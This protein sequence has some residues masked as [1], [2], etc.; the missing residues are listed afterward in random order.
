LLFLP[1]LFSFLLFFS[2]NS[3]VFGLTLDEAISLG[4]KN[5]LNLQKQQIDLTSGSFSERNVWSEIFPTINANASA[6]YR[7]NV[8]SDFQTN[9][10]GANYGIGFGINLGLNAGIPHIINNIKLAHQGNLLRYEDAVNQLSI[11]ITKRFFALVAEKNNLLLLEEILNLAQRQFSR[12]LISFQSGLVTELVMMQSRLALEN[13]RY[14]LSAAST[15]YKNNM[16][17]FLATLDI[18]YNDDITL[19]GEIDIIKIIVDAEMLIGEHL[20]LRPD[21]TR[22]KQE[23]ERLEN[24]HRRTV[25]QS[26]APSLNL[27]VDWSSSDFDPLRDTLSATARLN[28]PIDPWITGTSRA[29]DIT[30]AQDSIEKAKLDLEMTEE[31]ARMQ[32]RSL[33]AL[34]QGSWD[35]ILIARLSLDVARRTYQLTEQGFLSGRIEALVLEDVRNNM[36]NVRQRLLQTELSYFNM[37]LDLSA[38]LNVD[39]ENLI[40]TFGVSDEEE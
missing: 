24:I 26:R 23:I 32:I 25:L 15:V 39:W 35:S 33:A 1:F 14:D 12:A 21:I 28:I 11:Q 3:H 37:I 22:N 34:L 7:T 6:G 2:I 10:P 19:T 9:N 31:T 16:T 29:Q 8:F 13:A 4:I 18:T 38:A 40:K 5:N 36:A 17:E 27:S 20:H 30:R